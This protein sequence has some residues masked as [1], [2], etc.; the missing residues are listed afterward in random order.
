MRRA[1]AKKFE[2]LVSKIGGLIKQVAPE[3]CQSK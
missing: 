2:G 3:I 1:P